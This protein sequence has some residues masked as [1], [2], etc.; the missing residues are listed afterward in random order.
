MFFPDSIK[1]QKKQFNPFSTIINYDKYILH[2][3]LRTYKTVPHLTF[4]SM[5]TYRRRA[6]RITRALMHKEADREHRHVSPV[7][8]SCNTLLF[9][10]IMNNLM[11]SKI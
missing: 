9:H 4:Y 2:L 3:I 5:C 11:Y 8:I 7:N 10:I 1:G 6:F